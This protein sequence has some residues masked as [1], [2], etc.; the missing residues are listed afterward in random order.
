MGKF[1]GWAL[2]LTSI[3]YGGYFLVRYIK[4]KLD[5]S[6]VENEAERLFSSNSNVPYEKV[7]D[8]IIKKAE[9]QEIPLRRD[10]INI[11]IDDWDGY[12]VLTFSYTDSLLIF[13]FKTV[14]FKFSFTDTV[15]YR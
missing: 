3:G 15:F 13:N 8:E 11:Y 10:D 6:T 5:Y 1:F 14:Y 2:I 4:V 9:A 12:R 7:P